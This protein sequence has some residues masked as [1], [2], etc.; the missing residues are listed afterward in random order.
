MSTDTSTAGNSITSDDVLQLVGFQL[1][2]EEFGIE[3]TSIQ[4]INR[5]PFITRVPNSPYHVK[6]VMNLRG[7]TVPVMDLRIRLSMDNKPFTDDTRIIVVKMETEVIGFI[8]DS[9][10]EVIR[11]SKSNIEEPPDFLR[12]IDTEF[13]DSV[14]KIKGKL[15]ILLDLNKILQTQTTELPIH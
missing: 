2:N 14:G 13:I 11:L 6:G 15:L 8:V 4:E 10:T 9:V 12:T 5:M 7:K 3:I 1:G